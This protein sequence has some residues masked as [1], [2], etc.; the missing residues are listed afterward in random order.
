MI[1]STRITTA[2]LISSIAAALACAQHSELPTLQQTLDREHALLQKVLLGPA[3]YYTSFHSE[4][5][6]N[7]LTL[8]ADGTKT[9]TEID[10]V[11]VISWFISRNVVIRY[12][13]LETGYVHDIRD[14]YNGALQASHSRELDKPTLDSLR[15]LIT[16]L[17]QTLSSTADRPNGAC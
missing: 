13:V 9:E 4:P 10:R 14:V 7:V 3:S 16:Q 11:L 17:P 8:S 12:S 6:R 5:K 1:S 15:K 2:V